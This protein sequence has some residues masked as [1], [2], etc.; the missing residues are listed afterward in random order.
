MAE[1]DT[2]AAELTERFTFEGEAEVAH[3]AGF[4]RFRDGVIGRASI[5]RE[6]SAD[7]AAG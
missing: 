7:P 1:G 4:Y 3:L 5:Y 2:V 6:G